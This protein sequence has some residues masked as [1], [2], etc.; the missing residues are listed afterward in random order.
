MAH[1]VYPERLEPKESPVLHHQLWPSLLED[2]GDAPMDVLETLARTVS[3][4]TLVLKE[5]VVAT[6]VPVSQ[7][8]M[9]P[10][11]LPVVRGNLAHLDN[12]V[13][14]EKLA[15]TAPVVSRDPMERLAVVVRL[16]HA[17]NPAHQATQEILDNKD[18]EVLPAT[19]DPVVKME[20]LASPVKW[21][22]LD[23]L[24]R[25]LSIV[26]VLLAARLCSV[27]VAV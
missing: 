24:E 10:L 9:V 1:V 20:I 22:H 11:V 19:K 13:L 16:A 27:I 14:Q 26:L 8:L 15:T 6:D 25:M 3:L 21:D 4:V 7:G 23:N 5:N 12:P 18:E 2:V 17:V